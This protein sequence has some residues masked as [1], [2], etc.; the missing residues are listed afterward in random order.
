MNF[1]NYSYR[2]KTDENIREAVIYIL[3]FLSVYCFPGTLFFTL[4]H[5]CVFLTWKPPSRGLFC[6]LTFGIPKNLSRR[7]KL[8]YPLP[9]TVSRG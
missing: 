4:K 5:G 8:R 2:Y 1:E 7:L 3:P 6:S 9:Y